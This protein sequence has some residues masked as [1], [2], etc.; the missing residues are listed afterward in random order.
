MSIASRCIATL[1]LLLALAVPLA[2]QGTL[3]PDEMRRTAVQALTR[4]QPQAVLALTG[5]LLIRDP[6]DHAALVLRARALRDLGQLQQAQ[7]S[8]RRA[9][10][11]SATDP[12]RYVAALV[13][14]QALASDGQRTRAQFWLRRATQHAPDD[15]ARSAAIRDFRYVRARNPL[16]LQ[17]SFSVAPN[18]NINN[19]STTGRSTFFDPFTQSFVEVELQGAALALSGMEASAGAALRWRFAETQRRAT[20]ITLSFA[21]RSY[22]LSDSAQ[23]LAPTARGSDFASTTLSAGLTQRWRAGDGRTEYSLGGL[24]GLNRYGGAAY[25][26]FGR[27]TLGMNRALSPRARLH[28]DLS[29]DVT[30]G[31]RAPHAEALRFGAALERRLDSGARL[32][33]QA[34]L[35]RSRSAVATADYRE[36]SL[37]LRLDPR[38]EVLGASLSMGLSL[39][40]RD[41]PFTPFAAGT[42]RDRS[43]EAYL[44][45]TFRQVDYYG[46]NPVMTLRAART[47]SNVG[48]YTGDQLGIEFGVTSAF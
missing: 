27:V 8:A 45:L 29:G 31:P 13:M 46:F 25:G 9:W 35:A 22:S 7:E 43:A 38:G 40:A 5:A 11:V 3:T 23:A 12:Q 34:G 18:S 44:S 28:L 24:L 17:L 47:Q 2:A 15:R 26:E 32:V 19:G 30:R 37:G 39:R 16:S 4:G 42:R 36:A 20:D 41:Y 48:L 6:G 14:A 10:S 33:W 1:S 21:H